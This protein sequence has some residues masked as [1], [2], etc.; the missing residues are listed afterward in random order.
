MQ[1][2]TVIG[3][4]TRAWE[5]NVHWELYSH[6]GVWDPRSRGVNIF[7]CI[8]DRKSLRHSFLRHIL[9]VL[10]FIDDSVPGTQPPNTNYWR[11]IARR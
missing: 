8:R 11:F 5:L 1:R 4:A 7:E 9:I 6:C 2:T 3:D 10:S